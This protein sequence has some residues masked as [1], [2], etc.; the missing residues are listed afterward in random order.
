MVGCAHTSP[1]AVRVERVD[2]SVHSIRLS[3][4]QAFPF[5]HRAVSPNGREVLSKHFVLDT[6]GQYKP[7]GD[8][9]SR[10]FAR[11]LIL[12]D[13]QPYDVEILVTQEQR[14]LK[15]NH[16]TYEVTGHNPRL[17][18]DLERR[19]HEEL[20]KRREERNIIDDFRVF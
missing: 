17:A 6:R 18:K 1:Y 8:A 11:V 12:G 20:S 7:A 14:V 9:L 3:A 10:Y 13:R 5:G 4:I 15:G 2:M 19:L 16:F